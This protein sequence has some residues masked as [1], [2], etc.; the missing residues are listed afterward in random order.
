MTISKDLKNLK[1]IKIIKINKV[2][3]LKSRLNQTGY[4]LTQKIE[5]IFK[6]F[7]QLEL[8]LFVFQTFPSRHFAACSENVSCSRLAKLDVTIRIFSAGFCQ[9][10]RSCLARWFRRLPFLVSSR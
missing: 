4:N 3:F 2:Y 9:V 5:I 10:Q 1:S 8:K 6:I 7:N